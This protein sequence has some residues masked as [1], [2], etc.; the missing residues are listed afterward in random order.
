M[1]YDNVAGFYLAA[2]RNYVLGKD[3]SKLPYAIET[4]IYAIYL[5]LG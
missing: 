1:P 4:V 3:L 5:N 2:P